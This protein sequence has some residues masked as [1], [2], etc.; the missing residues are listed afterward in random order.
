M[1]R[2]LKPN[3]YLCLLIGDAW[4]NQ[5][6][7]PLGFQLFQ[8]GIEIGFIPRAIIIKVQHHV[9]GKRGVMGIWKWRSIKWNLFLFEHEYL[10]IFK[11][12]KL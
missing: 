8:I 1:Y 12:P 2:V 7:T 3:H 5:Q 11:K 4:K 10:L 9:T 6:L